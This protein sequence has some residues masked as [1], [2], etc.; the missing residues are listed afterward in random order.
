MIWAWI[1]FGI[2]IGWLGTSV[3]HHRL[4]RENLRLYERLECMTRAVNFAKVRLSSRVDVEAVEQIV[5]GECH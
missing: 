1:L 3:L 4:V 5:K 2:V